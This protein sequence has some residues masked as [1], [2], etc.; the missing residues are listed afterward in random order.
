LLPGDRAFLS[1]SPL[2][3]LLLKNLTPASRRQ[4]HTTSPSASSALVSST[5]SVH[6]I[7]PRVRDDRDTP[8]EWGETA[9]VMKLI[10][11]KHEAQY[12]LRRDWTGRN[13][14]NGFKKFNFARKSW[15]ASSPALLAMTAGRIAGHRHCE[16]KRSNPPLNMTGYGLESSKLKRLHRNRRLAVRRLLHLEF[17]LFLHSRFLNR[18]IQQPGAGRR[19]PVS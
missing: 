9:G 1:P 17:H 18:H 11:V 7:P 10:W 8:L 12:F 2:R 19:S 14:L 6:R 15:I 3:S 13:S 5:I 16:R 4:D